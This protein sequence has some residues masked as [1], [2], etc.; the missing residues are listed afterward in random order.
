MKDRILAL[1]APVRHIVLLLAS[2]L[3]AWG[4]SDVVPFLQNQSNVLGAVS[5][6]AVLAF[7][8]YATPLVAS[9]GVGAER[10][11]ELGARQPTDVSLSRGDDGFATVDGLGV[12]VVVLVVLIFL[13]VFGII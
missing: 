7:L 9:Y 10:A 6:A 1:P 3:L 11:R 13:R 5:A 2:V 4:G 12:V 8:A